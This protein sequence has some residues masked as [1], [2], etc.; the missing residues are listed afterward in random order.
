[1]NSIQCRS[2]NRF[3]ILQEPKLSLPS[4]QKLLSLHCFMLTSIFFYFLPY[5]YCM[6]KSLITSSAL[7]ILFS[8]NFSVASQTHWFAHMRQIRVNNSILFIMQ[9][10]AQLSMLFSDSLFSFGPLMIF[11]HAELL[12]RS[13]CLYPGKAACLENFQSPS[14]EMCPQLP[15]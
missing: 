7:A 14:F 5:H 9:P 3:Y 8:S 1:M 6:P 4:Y 15:S 10:F 12:L 13:I 11:E 2:R